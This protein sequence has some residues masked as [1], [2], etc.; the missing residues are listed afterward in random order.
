MPGVSVPDLLSPRPDE[1]MA[2]G[3][4][5]VPTGARGL[6]SHTSPPPTAMTAIPASTHKCTD[7]RGAG[8]WPAALGPAAGWP[9]GRLTSIL[10]TCTG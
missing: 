2:G 7:R 1:A 4:A 10:K 9:A 3:C 6:F 5:S 8:A